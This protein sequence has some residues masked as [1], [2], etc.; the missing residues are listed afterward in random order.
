MKKYVLFVLMSLVSLGVMAQYSRQGNPQPQ[1]PTPTHQHNSHNGSYNDG[2][3]D[4]YRDGQR[5]ALRDQQ[6][7]GHH[8]Q[9]KPAPAPAPVVHVANP[10]Q[11]QFALQMIEKQ[12]Y[13]DKRMEV[14]KLC[15]TLCPFTVRDLARMAEKFTKEDRKVDFLIYAHKYCADKENY[16]TLCNVL[17]YR[18]DCDKLMERVQPGYRR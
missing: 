5:D 18:S 15:V 8:E 1:G 9:H 3:R 16:Y 17:R 13:D 10:E 6:K 14:A 4:G 7:N 2:Y 11:V 12:S